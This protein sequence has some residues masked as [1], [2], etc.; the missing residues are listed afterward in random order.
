MAAQRTGHLQ[1][2]EKEILQKDPN[3]PRTRDWLYDHIYYSFYDGTH[4]YDNQ[5]SVNGQVS[6]RPHR[7]EILMFSLVLHKALIY[8]NSKSPD[9]YHPQHC[10]S[11]RYR[12]VPTVGLE[13]DVICRTPEGAAERVTLLHEFSPLRLAFRHTFTNVTVNLIMPLRGRLQALQIFLENV[14][15]VLTDNAV[16]LGL[17]LVY[18]DDPESQ[19]VR[20]VLQEAEN[21]LPNLQTE[22]ILLE[23]KLGFSRGHGLQEGVEK[24]K[25]KGEVVFFCD[26]DVL[27]TREFLTRCQTTPI[28]GLQ[29]FS[30]VVFS[31]YNPHLHPPRLQR[32]IK[33]DPQLQRQVKDDLG[34][35]RL[36]GHG[37]AC[38]FKS[39]FYE[40]A[41]FSKTS[42][43]GGEDLNFL[44]NVVNHG[45]YKVIRSLDPGLF[46]LYH[47]KSCDKAKNRFT[48]SM[49]RAASEASKTS[50]GLWYFK[51]TDKDASVFDVMTC[52][53]PS[54]SSR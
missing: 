22:F 7:D 24:S 36:W 17:T 40:L 51:H 30:P 52:G 41:T 14:K 46:H 21:Q 15:D 43:W 54:T 39:D 34:Y 3:Y 19:R 26:V 33:D 38:L 23:K 44:K 25:L 4:V 1:Q 2:E 27:F 32:R 8:L 53:N 5:A 13:F 18:F 28:R 20:E 47:A 42:G 12:T 9:R 37:M 35:W 31:Q 49:V 48:C 6:R 10:T 16:E 45:G 50:L 29:V 11:V